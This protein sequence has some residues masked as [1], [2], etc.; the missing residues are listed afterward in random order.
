[1]PDLEVD[2]VQ[3]GFMIQG[4]IFSLISDV[5]IED[6]NVNSTL[7]FSGSWFR[8]RNNNTGYEKVQYTDAV[9]KGRYHRNTLTFDPL[10][11]DSMD[12][13]YYVFFVNVSANSSFIKP[14]LASANV[15]LVISGYPKLNISTTLKTGRCQP[16]RGANLS[17][18]VN[19]LNSTSCQRNITHTWIKTGIKIQE[20]IGHLLLNYYFQI[21]SLTENDMGIYTVNICLTIPRSGLENHCSNIS[22]NMLLNGE[23]FPDA[24][25]Y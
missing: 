20:S 5:T 13:G 9:S 2:I 10:K 7:N 14:V 22:L 8:A 12:G 6:S 4:T 21:E 16:E 18:S 23:V 17:S 24:I 19:I 25:I 11:D 1:M 15:T 3:E